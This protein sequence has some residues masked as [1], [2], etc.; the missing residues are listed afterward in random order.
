MQSISA[1][2]H[3]CIISEQLASL[4]TIPIDIRF[5]VPVSRLYSYLAFTPAMAYNSTVQAIKTFEFEHKFRTK[6]Q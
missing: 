5:R 1:R 6:V 3:V 2:V 4:S